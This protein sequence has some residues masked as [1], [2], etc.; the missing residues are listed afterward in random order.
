MKKT[1]DKDRLLRIF[2]G[3]Y[4]KH[5]TEEVGC[6]YCAAPFSEWDHCP[7]LSW[8]DTINHQKYKKVLLKCCSECNKLLSDKPLFTAWERVDF[9]ENKLNDKLDECVLVE[10][11]WGEIDK[12]K[13]GLI[14]WKLTREKHRQEMLVARIRAAQQRLINYDSFPQE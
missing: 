11:S 8:M 7:P 9:I 12:M 3:L 4:E 1:R 13:D 14:K 10:E 5:W 2:G 6:F